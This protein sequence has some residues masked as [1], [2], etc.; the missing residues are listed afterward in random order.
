MLIKILLIQKIQKLNFLTNKYLF[1]NYK[2]MT[3]TIDQI[4]QL[5]ESTGV[6]MMACKK[7]L[8]E[9]SGDFDQAIDL[10]RKK[11]EAKAADRSERST[12]QGAVAIKSDNGKSAMVQLLCE[13]DFVAKGDEFLALGEL[14]ADKLL[15]G[16]ITPEDK[17][18]AEVKEAVLKLGE[19]IQVGEMKLIE[20]ENLGDYVHT[21]RKIGVLVSLSGGDLDLAKNIAMHVAATNP[22]VLS[23]SDVDNAL[24]EKEKG[25]WAEQLA[26]EGKPAEIIDKIMF[27]KEKKFRE[28][29]ALI[30][31]SFVKDPDKTIEQLLQESE[32]KINEFVR[33]AI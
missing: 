11:G 20:G 18:I 4:K 24:I 13:T 19:N 5:R 21:N 33:L 10:L 1:F 23:P 15:K 29:N 26:S 32:A 7:A 6:S 8:E 22:S 31:Q 17:D 25:I 30:K 2:I 3:V 28:E 27:G 14:L 12:S 16:E 9:T